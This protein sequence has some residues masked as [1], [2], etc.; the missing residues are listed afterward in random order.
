MK[1]IQIAQTQIGLL[2][3][4]DDGEVYQWNSNIKGW[5]DIKD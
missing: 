4:G 3:V 1:I 5:V 2:G